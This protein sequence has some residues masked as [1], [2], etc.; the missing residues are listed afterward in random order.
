CHHGF[1]GKYDCA[2]R[3]KRAERPPPLAAF[4]LAGA[5]YLRGNRRAEG[6]R[7][8]RHPLLRSG[9]VDEDGDQADAA[10]TDVRGRLQ[11]R[12]DAGGIDAGPALANE[13]RKVFDRVEPLAPLDA[14]VVR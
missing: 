5:E 12:V 1:W 7:L 14:A 4:A 11:A 2:V 13:G 10:G 3:W 8:K 9:R 6:L